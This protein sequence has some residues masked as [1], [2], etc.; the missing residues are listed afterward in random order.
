MI[1]ST[2]IVACH[3]DHSTNNVIENGTIRCIMHDF[4]SLGHCKYSIIIIII[5]II[6]L[7]CT[8]F[9]RNLTLKNNNIV[10]SKSRLGVNRPANMHCTWVHTCK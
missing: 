2:L 4:L 10:T 1:Y 7:S 3:E 6:L 5:K 9:S 8:L